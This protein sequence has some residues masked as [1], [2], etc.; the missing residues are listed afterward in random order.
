[1]RMP[2]RA[3]QCFQPYPKV[4]EKRSRPADVWLLFKGLAFVRL[5]LLNFEML[6]KH[7]TYKCNQ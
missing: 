6:S 5:Y 1:M 2:P 7:S 4:P 3:Q